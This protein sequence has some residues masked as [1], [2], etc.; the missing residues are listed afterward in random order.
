M[1]KTINCKELAA[2]F[3]DQTQTLQQ[4]AKDVSQIG[5]TI[6]HITVKLDEIVKKYEI[7]ED[8]SAISPAKGSEIIEFSQKTVFSDQC[9]IISFQKDGKSQVLMPSA[10]GGKK[11]NS[12]PVHFK[13]LTPFLASPGMA[14]P[15][16]IKDFR[17]LLQRDGLILLSW[18]MRRTEMGDRYTAYWVT[19]NGDPR[20]NAS[21]LLPL[22]DFSSARPDHKSYAA[23]DG[24]EFYGQEAPS[25]IVHV[26]PELM[27]S[28]P[29]HRELRQTH[30]NTLKEMGV[31]VD[32]DYKYLLSEE[33]RRFMVQKKDGNAERNQAG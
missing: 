3:R 21:K 8:S 11:N 22:P 7:I 18:D 2:V 27:K 23:E 28:N 13:A 15:K 33:K 5:A 26:A 32:F 16:Q 9:K 30:I 4:L 12:D 20:F 24:I 1:A 25:Y 19:S 14:L 31:T 10:V 29:H 6:M 17:P